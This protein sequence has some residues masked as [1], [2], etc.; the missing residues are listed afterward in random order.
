MEQRVLKRYKDII[1]KWSEFR[2]ECRREVV[3]TVTKNHVKAKKDFEKRL[4]QQYKEVERA[5]WNKDVYRL[6]RNVKPGK[7]LLHW[8]GEY[9]A[10][11][12]SATIPMEKLNP[13]K[14]DEILDMCAAPGG[15]TIQAA[16][17]TK[18][19]ANIISND[20]N[21]RR[22]QSLHANVYRTGATS[23]TVTNYDG[24]QIP[25][26]QKYDKILV[27]APCSGEGNNARRS[28]NEASIDEI[29]GLARL[30][31]K[32]LEKAWNMTKPGGAILYS[33]CTFAPQENEAVVNHLLREKT[34]A[35]LEELDLPFNHCK[36]LTNYQDTYYEDSMNKTLRVYPHHLNSGG[37]YIA[38][39]KKQ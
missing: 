19:N 3:Q 14:G 5:E 31:K 8:L 27:D 13:D 36:G 9:Y 1:P 26:T 37:M 16:S 11:E 29:K 12:E 33:T 6:G 2:E 34:G 22:L 32:L 38:K 25:E 4:K 21:S 24:R 18:N 20:K 15:K 17:K 7:S 35:E 30:Q 23:V 39:I 10:Q 28:F